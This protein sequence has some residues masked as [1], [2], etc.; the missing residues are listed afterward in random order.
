M[1]SRLEHVVGV[2][3]RGGPVA[4]KALKST[5]APAY[6]G[7]KHGAE[8]QRHEQRAC[9]GRFWA[10]RSIV[11]PLVRDPM[12]GAQVF[13]SFV[14]TWSLPA[15]SWAEIG[16]S[17]ADLCARMPKV[18]NP[19]RR[20]AMRHSRARKRCLWHQPSSQDQLGAPSSERDADGPPSLPD[21]GP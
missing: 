16:A 8:N 5:Y 13:L 2:A 1:L 17:G 21:F 4:R 18:P 19:I 11:W 20:P 14:L 9:R 15:R 3:S 12:R 6:P 7:A 10:Q